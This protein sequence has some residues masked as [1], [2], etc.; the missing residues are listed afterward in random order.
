MPDVKTDLKIYSTVTVGG[1][2]ITTTVPYANG[3]LSNATLLEFA[4]KLNSLTTNTFSYA[5]KVVTTNLTTGG[6]N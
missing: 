2:K 1:Q 6:G 5:E 4:Q 3:S